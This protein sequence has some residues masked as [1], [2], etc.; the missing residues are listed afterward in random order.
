LY[1][2]LLALFDKIADTS[3]INQNES[4]DMLND[5]NVMLDQKSRDYSEH[6]IDQSLTII[7]Q[8]QLKQDSDLT[9]DNL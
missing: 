9:N 6:K 8:T 2:N 1:F 3:K 5:F 4:N 7:T